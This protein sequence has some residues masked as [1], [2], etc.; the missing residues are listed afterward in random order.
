MNPG[1]RIVLG[2]LRLY[3]VVVSPV[4]TTLARP[5]GLGCRFTPTCSHYAVEAVSRFGV[6]RGLGLAVRRLSRC[7]PW[8]PWGYDPVPE[9]VKPAGRHAPES[10]RRSQRGP[11]TSAGRRPASGK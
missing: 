11:S 5:W 8:G 9:R 1:Q 10:P 6:L 3:Q 2:L 7:H 4:W